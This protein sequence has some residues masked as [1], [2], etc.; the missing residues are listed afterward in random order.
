M[1]VRKYA[2]TGHILLKPR[3]MACQGWMDGLFLMQIQ[4]DL[5][6]CPTI[7][8]INP[9][10]FI[11]RSSDIWSCYLNGVV[12]PL[13]RDFLLYHTTTHINIRMIHKEGNAGWFSRLLDILHPIWRNFLLH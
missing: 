9:G 3:V 8:Q 10:G 7:I 6:L 11:E 4:M 5:L 1:V 12:P 2:R 13:W